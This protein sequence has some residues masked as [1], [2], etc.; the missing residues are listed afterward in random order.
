M[1]RRADP[2]SLTSHLDAIDTTAR[3]RPSPARTR[4]SPSV[5]TRLA[6]AGAGPTG[7]ELGAGVHVQV[8]TDVGDAVDRELLAQVLDPPALHRPAPGPA[9]QVLDRHGGPSTGDAVR[10]RSGPGH[11]AAPDGGVDPTSRWVTTTTVR[12]PR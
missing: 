6:P 1:H 8:A 10:T 5:T 7:Q 12:A 11:V 4:C 2:A 3:L 9:E